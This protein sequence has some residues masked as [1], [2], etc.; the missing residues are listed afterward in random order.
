MNNENYLLKT[1][2][3]TASHLIVSHFVKHGYKHYSIFKN[4]PTEVFNSIENN[5]SAIVHDHSLDH[6][7]NT[8]DW[9]LIINKRKDLFSLALSAALA[10]KNG[11][12]GGKPRDETYNI[13]IEKN[14]FEIDLL[15]FEC[16]L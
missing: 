11:N 9:N 10:W 13:R 14:E 1:G 7:V 16:C 15:T 3:R 5:T 8:N 6:P 12:Y 2:G 4:N